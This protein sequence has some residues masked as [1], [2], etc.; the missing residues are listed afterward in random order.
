MLGPRQ[1]E[2]VEEHA[3]ER[4]VVVLA[5]VD[6][7]LV[8]DRAQPRGDGRGLDELRA[9]A[10]DGEDAHREEAY[11][12]PRSSQLRSVGSGSIGEPPEYQPGAVQISKCR[13]QPLAR[14]V[15]PTKPI[16]WPVARG[17]RS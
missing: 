2:L 13:W 17:R 1:R 15:W 3:R 8:A 6:E 10:D 9:V 4:V 14:P 12:Q 5:G 11:G 7:H 16:G